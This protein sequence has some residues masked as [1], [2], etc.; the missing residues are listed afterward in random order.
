MQT[1]NKDG[2]L[3][4]I[5]KLTS[6]NLADALKIK[7]IDHV[8]VFDGTPQTIKHRKSL[9]GKKYKPFKWKTEKKY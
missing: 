9:I 5:Q 7:N 2:I 8:D 3:G 4:E 1:V 6:E